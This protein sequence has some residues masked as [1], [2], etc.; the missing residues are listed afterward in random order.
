MKNPVCHEL[1]G[2]TGIAV[3]NVWIIVSVI[4]CLALVS[5]CEQKTGEK[6]IDIRKIENS[7]QDQPSHSKDISEKSSLN[8]KTIPDKPVTG[9][10]MGLAFNPE[11]F[12][13]SDAGNLEIWTGDRFFPDLKA[14]IVLCLGLN[15][16]PAGKTYEFNSGDKENY[17]PSIILNRK[18]GSG[19]PERKSFQKGYSLKLVFGEPNEHM[20]TGRIFLSVPGED[21]EFSGV[22]SV[23]EPENPAQP[24]EERHMPYMYGQISFSPPSAGMLTAGYAGIGADD[25]IY[26]NSAGMKVEPDGPL[27]AA[28][29]TS[30][31]FAPRNTTMWSDAN[32]T[33]CFRHVHMEPGTY[34]FS[35]LW[36]GNLIYHRCLNVERDS[37]LKLNP[38][39]DLNTSGTI[40][41]KA[42]DRIVKE[43]KEYRQFEPVWLL[44]AGLF[45]KIQSGVHEKKVWPIAQGL[46][47]EPED[48]VKKI[49]YRFLPPGDYLISF[50]DH[51]KTVNVKS[52]KQAEVHFP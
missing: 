41:V 49:T 34:V 13:I 11:K 35:V 12:G 4:Y 16:S 36:E 22:F 1:A 25:K 10:L 32:G 38:V 7:Q 43:A 8:A 19:F 46:Q 20:L 21:T 24:P 17:C 18:S 23:E 2:C 9:K 26:S 37:S 47:I 44:P 33:I 51:M 30:T 14:G 52:D 42:P 48:K 50:K 31:T 45:T 15:Q 6:D 5:G 28:M 40:A 29:V 3:R 27:G 39:I